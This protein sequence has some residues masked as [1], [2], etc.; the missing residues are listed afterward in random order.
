MTVT[1]TFDALGQTLL[2]NVRSIN[3]QILFQDVVKLTEMFLDNNHNYKSI[4]NKLILNS[5]TKYL[6]SIKTFKCSLFN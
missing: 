3:E 4:T 5:T 2:N 6:T 1:I